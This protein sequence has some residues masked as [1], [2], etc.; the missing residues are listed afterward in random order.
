MKIY[1]EKQK[2]L[3]ASVFLRQGRFQHEIRAIALALVFVLV[4]APQLS[5]KW[6]NL[7]EVGRGGGEYRACEKSTSGSTDSW[8][9]TLLQNRDLGNLWFRSRYFYVNRWRGRSCHSLTRSLTSLLVRFATAA[10]RAPLEFSGT[11][12]DSDFPV[13][14]WQTSAKIPYTGNVNHGMF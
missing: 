12:L 13:K 6:S 10:V 5:S 1:N 9:E 4:L 2:M 3:I 11:I 7:V 14:T 8:D